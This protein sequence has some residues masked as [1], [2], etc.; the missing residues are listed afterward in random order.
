[1]IIERSDPR[2]P[3]FGMR[4]ETCRW[5]EKKSDYPVLD[6]EWGNCALIVPYHDSSEDAHAYLSLSPDWL[7]TRADFGCVQWEAKH[8]QADA[9]QEG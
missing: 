2:H 5:W 6:T 3:E 4:C 9:Q 8:E 7:V 1:M